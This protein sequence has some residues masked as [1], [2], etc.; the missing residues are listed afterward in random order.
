MLV[1]GLG[2]GPGLI[3]A[4]SFMGL[5][6][7]DAPMAAALSLMAQSIGY[8]VA[9]TGPTLFGMTHEHTG[10]WHIPMLAVVTLALLQ[11]FFGIGA[12][13]PLRVGHPAVA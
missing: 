12:G 13:R 4:L 11:G 9:A 2:A 10:S 7:H 6:A 8:S 1:L 5:R 3:L